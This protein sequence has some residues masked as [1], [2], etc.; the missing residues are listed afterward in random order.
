MTGIFKFRW[1]SVDEKHLIQF[2]GENAIFKSLYGSVD[3]G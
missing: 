3:R 2:Q 1:Y